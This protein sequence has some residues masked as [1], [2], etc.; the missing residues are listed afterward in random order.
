MILDHNKE[1]INP[2]KRAPLKRE[3]P[4]PSRSPFKP[5]PALDFDPSAGFHSGPSRRQ[6]YRLALWSW[7]ASLIDILILVSGSCFFVLLFSFI[8]QT[9]VGPLVRGLFHSQHQLLFFAEVGVLFGWLYMVSIRTLLGHSIG[10][11]A[12]DLRLGKPR[13]RLQTKYVFKVAFRSTVILLTGVVTLPILSLLVG[14]DLAGSL[15]G[16]RLFSLK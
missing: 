2:N 6:G 15:S 3:A 7:L 1:I 4:F 9:P 14:K 11:W 12:C 16:L 8:V 10:E 13:E 5:G